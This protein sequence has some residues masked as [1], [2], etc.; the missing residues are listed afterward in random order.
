MAY[1]VTNP[2]AKI[3][4]TLTGGSVWLFK[5]ADV[6]SDV[7]ASDYFSNGEALGMKV[8]DLVLLIDTATPKASFHSVSAIHADGNAT[9]SEEHT[10]DLQS[11]MRI[12]YAVFCLK[13]KTK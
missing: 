5:S 8:G 9:R 12:P 11:P 7:N 10:S 1:A 2:P 3:A 4:Q 13:K 6:D